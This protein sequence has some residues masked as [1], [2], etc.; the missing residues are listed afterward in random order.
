MNVP[1]FEGVRIHP[2]NTAAD[3]EGCILVGQTK[4]EEF[5]GKAGWLLQ[6][7][8]NNCKLLP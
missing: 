7:L 1:D 2:G 8:F 4:T 5:V 6:Q 3:T